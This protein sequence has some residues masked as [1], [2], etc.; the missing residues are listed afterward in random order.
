MA[1]GLDAPKA[2]DNVKVRLAVHPFWNHERA[3]AGQLNIG[4]ALM[5]H[6]TAKLP[7][8]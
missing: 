7:R 8:L 6:E 2:Q 1:E 5:G 3:W 4:G